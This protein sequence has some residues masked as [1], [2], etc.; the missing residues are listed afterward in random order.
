[1]TFGEALTAA[2]SKRDARTVGRCVDH[3][4]SRGMNYREIFSFAV[5]RVPSLTLPDWDELLEEADY[6]ES[7]S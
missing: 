2:I 1:M 5:G 4:R 7:R 3:L 6:L